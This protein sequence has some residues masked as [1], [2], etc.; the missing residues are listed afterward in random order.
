MFRSEI[1][2][3]RFIK[4]LSHDISRDIVFDAILRIR[5]STGR[6]FFYSEIRFLKGP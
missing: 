1:D 2:G 6:S 3:E 5:T 4:D